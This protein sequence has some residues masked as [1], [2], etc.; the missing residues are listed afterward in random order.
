MKVTIK[1]VIKPGND[2]CF[3]V[4][5]NDEPKGLFSYRDGVPEGDIYS[6]SVNLGKAKELADILEK[7]EPTFEEI[8]YESGSTTTPEATTWNDDEG[9]FPDIKHH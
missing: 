7:N 9:D 2:P 8:I 5:K 6:E 4:F 3:K 1:R